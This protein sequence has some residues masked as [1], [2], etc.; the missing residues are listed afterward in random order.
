MTW[1]GILYSV[2]ISWDGVIILDVTD[3]G[4]FCW[5]EENVCSVSPLKSTSEGGIISN[6]TSL[7]STS[8]EIISTVNGNSAFVK[9]DSGVTVWIVTYTDDID[10]EKIDSKTISLTMRPRT[11]MELTT[12]GGIWVGNFFIAPYVSLGTIIA[13]PAGTIIS[14]VIRRSYMKQKKRPKSK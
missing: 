9:S 7:I 1:N 4:T 13:I 2:L 11:F 8:S 12:D 5:I 10:Q 14:L 6:L 3:I